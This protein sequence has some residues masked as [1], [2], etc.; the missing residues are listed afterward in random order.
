[1][2][3]ISLCKRREERRGKQKGAADPRLGKCMVG[4]DIH[5]FVGLWVYVI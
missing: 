4:L 1:M 3:T 5:M 2:I